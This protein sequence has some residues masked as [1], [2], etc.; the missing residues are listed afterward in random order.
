MKQRL[1]YIFD[2][3]ILA[4]LCLAMDS[5]DVHEFPENPLPERPEHNVKIHLVHNQDLPLWKQ[6]VYKDGDFL[7]LSRAARGWYGP[8]DVRHIIKFY[9]EDS[10]S[11]SYSRTEDYTVVHTQPITAGL[12]ATVTAD[13][14]EGNYQ[15]IVWTDYVDA[16]SQDDKFYDTSDFSEVI[17]ASREGYASDDRRE[18]FRGSVNASITKAHYLE[19]GSIACAEPTVELERPQAKYRLVTTDLSRFIELEISR[20]YLTRGEDGSIYVTS[21]GPGRSSKAEAASDAETQGDGNSKSE[22]SKSEDSKGEDSRAV[23]LSDYRVVFRYTQYMPCSFNVFADRPA[24][25]W[26]GMSFEAEIKVLDDDEAEIG[27]DFVFINHHETAVVVAVDIYDLEGT[28]LSSS[29]PINI[30]IKRSYL[31]EVRSEFLTSTMGSGAGID[32]D[33]DGEFNIFIP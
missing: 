5:C 21:R 3:L 18:V 15:I 14:P 32:P 12:D 16:G 2:T 23:D 28:H 26:T 19:D 27:C 24:D 29:P 13:I 20:G 4:I 7:P 9:P 22:E 1:H 10:R 6:L 11:G 30:P 25:A 8:C 33:F 31:T 17:L